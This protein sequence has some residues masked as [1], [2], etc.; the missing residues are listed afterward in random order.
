MARPGRG[1]SRAEG[2]SPARP[3]PRLPLPRSARATAKGH[4]GSPMW[5]AEPLNCAQ[6]RLLPPSQACEV[7][8][9]PERQQ[10][11]A[12]LPSI[13]LWPGGTLCTP[14]THHLV[15]PASP[16]RAGVSERVARL[17]QLDS[18]RAAQSHT[19]SRP[20]LLASPGGPDPSPRPRCVHV[21]LLLQWELSP[22]R[23]GRMMEGSGQHLPSSR[24]GPGSSITESRKVTCAL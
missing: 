16:P 10:F 4:Q 20:R 18:T 3:G 9:Q 19:C 21:S 5:V 12:V 1:Q 15:G 22:M 17:Q 11:L 24:C 8:S 6:R 13:P 7:P 2:W 23:S 14:G